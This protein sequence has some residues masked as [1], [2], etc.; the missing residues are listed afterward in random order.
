MLSTTA[1][2]QTY[3]TSVLGLS[4]LLNNQG[5]NSDTNVPYLPLD[6]SQGGIF[7]QNKSVQQHVGKP[8]CQNAAIAVP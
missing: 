4:T 2:K 8:I 3:L 1:E 7:T 5:M 6:V